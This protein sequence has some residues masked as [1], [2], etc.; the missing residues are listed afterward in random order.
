[1]L[2]SISPLRSWV[3]AS[4]TLSGFMPRTFTGKAC[5]KITAIASTVPKSITSL[6]ARKIMGHMA[7]AKG[8]D[9]AH[10]EVNSSQA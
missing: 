4:S 9:F 3:I 2:T 8:A 10:A 7:Q 5:S 6:T 1:M